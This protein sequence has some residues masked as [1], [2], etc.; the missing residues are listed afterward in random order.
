MFT[1]KV[2]AVTTVTAAVLLGACGS[3]P[4]ATEPRSP[5]L[6]NAA[7]APTST[8]G[9]PTVST[10]GT[11][12]VTGTPD[13]L[14]V[15][16]DVSTTGLHAS[17]ALQANN[18]V[19]MRVQQVLARDG[20]PA[21]QLQTSNLSLDQAYNGST[22][23]GYTADDTLSVTLRDMATAGT[24]VD[25]AITAAGDAGRLDGVY[26]SMSDTN[27]LM[28]AARQRGVEAARAQAEQLAAAA[29]ERLGS[30]VSISDQP[31]QQPYPAPIY[32]GAM[33]S[34]AAGR[35]APVPVQPGTQQLSVQVS[36]VWALTPTAAGPPAGG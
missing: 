2:L 9:G 27:P 6:A 21:T 11:G 10:T 13:T 20:V 7:T 4:P 30:L 5:V 25:D 35:A 23:S 12:T 24:V 14:T 17:Q 22:P 8:A 15:Q 28:A 3:R 32:T 16:I 31:Q 18:A 29:G 34:A 36:A 26:L 1:P 19:S 33:A